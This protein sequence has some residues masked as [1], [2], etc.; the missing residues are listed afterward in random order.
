MIDT[1]KY[2]G[3]TEGP[4][5]AEEEEREDGKAWTM[6]GGEHWVVMES[7]GCLRIDWKKEDA[8]LAAD[9]PLLL[10]EYKRL[11]CTRTVFQTPWTKSEHLGKAHLY[12]YRVQFYEE[13]LS[14]VEE[15][16]GE[17]GWYTAYFMVSD[18]GTKELDGSNECWDADGGVHWPSEEQRATG[19]IHYCF[20]EGK[21]L[22]DYLKEMIE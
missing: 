11:R 3:H 21:A 6:W 17:D 12:S 5:Y 18:H 14:E 2:E 20:P 22:A 4:W 15:W 7:D 1:D 19:W 13:T 8:L 10:E 16:R 9:A